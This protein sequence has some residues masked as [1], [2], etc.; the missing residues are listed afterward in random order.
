MRLHIARRARLDDDPAV[1]H[2]REQRVVLAERD[3][4]ADALGAEQVQRASDG[5][6]ACRF[7]RV[8]GRAKMRLARAQERGGVTIG[9]VVRLVAR[10]VEPTTRVSAAT[11]TAASAMDSDVSAQRLARAGDLAGDD[12]KVALTGLE[13]AVHRPHRVFHRQGVVRDEDRRVADLHVADVVCGLVLKELVRDALE[14]LRGLHHRR[15]EVERAQ[16]LTERRAA[17]PGAQDVAERVE[18]FRWQL[19]LLIA[20]QLKERGRPKRAVEVEVQLSLGGRREAWGVRGAG[21]RACVPSREDLRRRNLRSR[22]ATSSSE[23]M[24]QHRTTTRSM[25]RIESQELTASTE[26]HRALLAPG[27][28][29]VVVRAPPSFSRALSQLAPGPMGEVARGVARL[30]RGS[31][32]SGGVDALWRAQADARR[33]RSR[34]WRFSSPSRTRTVGTRRSRT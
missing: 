31:G 14:R 29:P 21:A 22:H 9:R 32:V 24:R 34:C 18:V 13:P 33:C 2:V 7:T 10:E 16:V 8:H 4:V 23:Q 19:D 20:G 30:R 25:S 26:P 5:R 28:L 15:G 1:A 27:T 12:V 17:G 11:A 3:A 6:R